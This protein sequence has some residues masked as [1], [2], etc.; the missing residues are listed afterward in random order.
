MPTIQS[1]AP[2]NGQAKDGHYQ[3]ANFTNNEQYELIES[4]LQTYE[5]IFYISLC[6]ILKKNEEQICVFEGEKAEGYSVHVTDPYKKNC[7]VTS[8]PYIDVSI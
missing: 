7:K 1:W 5:T 2:Q 6:L 8:A 3:A 4:N